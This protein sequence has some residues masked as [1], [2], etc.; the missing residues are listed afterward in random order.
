M[1]F[2][3]N[4]DVRFAPKGLMFFE[5]FRSAQNRKPTTSELVCKIHWRAWAG[6]HWPCHAQRAEQDGE[7]APVHS[8]SWGFG[9]RGTPGVL[10]SR[11]CQAP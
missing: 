8:G 3:L 6:W 11:R 9:G 10:C 4:L 1:L 7:S 2:L 5:L